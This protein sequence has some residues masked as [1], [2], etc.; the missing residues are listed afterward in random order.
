MGAQIFPARLS[1]MKSRV[2]M[3]HIHSGMQTGLTGRTFFLG[4][5]MRRTGWVL[6]QI[7]FQQNG[8]L[9]PLV[10]RQACANSA[11]KTHHNNNILRIYSLDMKPPVFKEHAPC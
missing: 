1:A 11:E 7:V 10:N 8:L 6:A 3:R 5:Q 2:I 4:H 9:A